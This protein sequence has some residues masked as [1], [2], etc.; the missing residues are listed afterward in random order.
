MLEN[1]GN[2]KTN[3]EIFTQR[4]TLIQKE[5]REKYALDHR[6]RHKVKE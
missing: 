3:G 6:R 2:L 4:E 1:Y 5:W